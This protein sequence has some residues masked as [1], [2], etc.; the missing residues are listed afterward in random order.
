VE[1]FLPFIVIGLATGAVYG[2]AGVGLVLTYKTSGIFNF[3]YGAVAAIVAFCFYFL[4]VDHGLAWPLAAII[5]VF[6]FAPVLG[7]LFELLAR[8]L[9][10]ASEAAKVVATV[11]VILI[12]AS[13]GSLWHPG[14]APTFPAFLPQSTVRML[15]VN[16]TWEQIILFVL[17]A[18]LAG[19]LYWFFRATRFGIVMRGVVDNHELVSM[20]G[21]D[22]VKVRRWAWIIGIVFAGLA[23][24]LLAS[25]QQLDGV[26]LTTVV[27]AA[28]GAA[29]IGYFSN[30]PLTFAGGLIVGVASALV[31]KYAVTVDWLGGLPPAL[32]FVVLFLVLIVLPRRLLT[33]RRLVKSPPVKRPYQAP[34]RIRLVA[35]AVAITLLALVPTIQSGRVV[36]WSVALINMMLFLSLGLLVRLSGQISLCHMAFAAVGA[37][38]FGHLATDLGLP[39]LV[40]LLVATL[41]AVPVGAIIAIPAIRVSGVFLALAT[42]GFGILMQQMFY[43][44]DFMF[45]TSQLGVESPRPHLTIGSLDLSSDNGFYYLLLLITVLVVLTVAFINGGRLGRLLEA[46]GDS[47]LALETHGAAS[48]VS[49]VIVFCIVS[50]IAAL[51]GA[52]YAQLFRFGVGTYFPAFTSLILIAVVMLVTVGFPWYALIA[53]ISFSVIPAYITGQNTTNVLNLLFG[54]G[55]VFIVYVL[56]SAGA[57]KPVRQFL[58]RVGGRKPAVAAGS[59]VDLAL[60]AMP[61]AA[62]QLA[63]TTSAAPGGV[64]VGSGLKVNNLSVHF[65]GVAAVNNLSLEAPAGKITGLIGPNGAGKTTTFNALSALNRPSSGRIMLHDIDVT[66][67]GPSRRARRGLGRTFQRTELFDSLTVRQN[68]AM[69][70]EA[71][72]AGANPLAHLAGSRASGKLINEVVDE[73]LTLT[74]ITNIADAQVGLLPIGQRRLVELARTLAGPFDLLLLDEPSSGLDIHET[75][76]F[77]RV[78]KAVVR[79]RGCGILLVEHDMTLVNETCDYV[80]VLDFGQ[81]IFEGTPSEMHNSDIVRAAYLGGTAVEAVLE[82][83]HATDPTTNGVLEPVISRK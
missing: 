66:D 39:W 79:D 50:A 41:I 54:L 14:L 42:L 10:D 23:G 77:G 81:L 29:A 43:S 64:P 61:E 65:G 1:D 7:L 22:P 59:T 32:P 28:F 73:A 16:V 76:Q 45:T 57:P 80:Y 60:I 27:F 62:S 36:L 38:A 52:L 55:A 13:L 53:A 4:H 17:S 83:D 31:S 26:T 58:D 63:Q 49:K 25:S 15:G 9:D 12:V 78:L 34:L 30:L 35:G 3:G 51:A 67:E 70:R 11:G 33:Q 46:L 47:P 72:M 19:G 48:S 40:A 6:V 8:V 5:S 82:D 24:L 20:A 37:A 44:R 74:G 75:E 69:G 2:L 56:R 68:V 71:S 18:G 21:D